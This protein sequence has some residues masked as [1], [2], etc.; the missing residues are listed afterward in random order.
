[1]GS[2]HVIRA[3]LHTTVQDTGRWGFQSHG[4]P[5]AGAMDLFAHRI[6]NAMVGNEPSAATLEITLTG[7]ELRLDD[8]RTIAVTGG[9]FDLFV[10]GSSIAGE[11]PV[12]VPGGSVLR[13]GERRHGARAYL[14]VSG[15][16]DV[17]IV[18]GSRS[19]HMPSRTGGLHGRALAAGDVVPL[20]SNGAP[21]AF[22][23]E[24]RVAMRTSAGDRQNRRLRVLPGPQQDR[25][26]GQAIA[27]LQSAPYVV[28]PESN[29]MGFRLSGPPLELRSTPDIISEP[30]PIG[31]LQVPASRQ[32]ILLMADRQ[33]AGGYAKLATV[34]TAD[35]G[36]AAQLAP[37]DELR[38]AVC[39]QAEALAA[40]IAQ[41]R[42]ILA[43]EGER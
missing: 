17:P 38:F 15:G 13:F 32:P 20:G 19:T 23:G 1:M 33:T 14:A 40:L 26:A 34:I 25:F 24:H 4:V 8:E 18:L 27:A 11:T 43:V 2:L 6:A 10:D 22:R 36:I 21:F 7:P 3:G 39:T 31:A 28:L 30:A 41:E 9:Q 5:V 37:G 42:A 29:R 16:V 35:I 12:V